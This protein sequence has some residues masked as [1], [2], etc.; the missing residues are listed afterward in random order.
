M[1]QSLRQL[2]FVSLVV[3]AVAGCADQAQQPSETTPATTK[4]P[5]GTVVRPGSTQMVF[6]SP[7]CPATQVDV[8]K[9][10]DQLLPQLF[11][12][13]QCAPRTGPGAQQRHGE[14]AERDNANL[15][16]I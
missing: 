7:A 13:G 9:A 16:N 10:V 15:A 6:V 1:K 5:T 8:Q 2:A 4:T 14:G 3:A 11:G 12:T